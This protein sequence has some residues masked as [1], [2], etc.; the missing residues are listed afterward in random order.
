MG[1]AGD[2]L[3]SAKYSK[4]RMFRRG[5]CKILREKSASTILWRKR[6]ET[7]KNQSLK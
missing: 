2:I 5:K 4:I 3:K 6:P 7:L 1:T